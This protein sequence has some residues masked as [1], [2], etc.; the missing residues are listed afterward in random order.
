[1]NRHM[2][3]VLS[4]LAVAAAIAALTASLQA[5]ELTAAIRGRAISVDRQP[6]AEVEVTAQ[7]ASLPATARTRTGRDGAYLLRGL[8]PGDYVITFRAAGYV[9]L[10]RTTRLSALETAAMD[11]ELVAAPQESYDPIVAVSEGRHMFIRWPLGATTFRTADVY[12]LPL[13]GTPGSLLAIMPGSQLLSAPSLT[14]WNGVPVRGSALALTPAY[15]LN[16]EALADMTLARGGQPVD[17]EA[18]TTLAVAARRGSDRLAGALLA[19]GG[20]AGLAGDALW[21]TG[22][23]RAGD[24]T[25]AA[26][27]GGA[28]LPRHVWF[29]AQGETFGEEFRQPVVF[30]EPSRTRI[31][32]TSASGSLTF[33]WANRQRVELDA[34]LSRHDGEARV[35]ESWR[36]ASRAGAFSSDDEHRLLSAAFLTQLGRGPA[37]ELRATEE[38]SASAVVGATP[39]GFSIASP[40]NETRLDGGFGC[41]GCGSAIRTIRSTRAVARQ[42]LSAGGGSHELTFGAEQVEDR[43]ASSPE[44]G[45]RFE[46]LASRFVDSAG[47]LF[48]MLVPNGSAALIWYPAGTSEGTTRTSSA[49]LADSWRAGAGLTL[50]VGVRWDR[51][52]IR[53]GSTGRLLLET[54][55][56]SPRVAL[57]WQPALARG[58]RVSLGYGRYASSS[59]PLAAT[60]F[61][62]GA[63]RVYTYTGPAINT[64]TA[65]LLSNDQVI[66][67][68]QAWAGALAT[69]VPS[70]V[71]G[72]GVI[73]EST[74][75][76]SAI[77]EWSGGISKQFRMLE[78]RA[79]VLHR[80]NEGRLIPGAV[81]GVTIPDSLTG[82]AIDAR[83]IALDTRRAQRS[84]DIVLQ[85]HYRLGLQ[86]VTGASYTH[87][88]PAG[89]HVSPVHQWQAQGL[90]YPE[91]FTNTDGI[92]VA[93]RHRTTA[94]MVVQMLTDPS[95]GML[96]VGALF[97]VESSPRFGTVGWIDVTPYTTNPGYAQPPAAV[98]Y[99]FAPAG[100]SD[101]GG[102]W[103]LDFALRYTKPFGLKNRA[104]WFVRLDVLNIADQKYRLDRLRPALAVTALQDPV[105]FA[106]FD[107]AT[108]TPARGVHWE[109]DPWSGT[110]ARTMPRAIRWIGGFR[111]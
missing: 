77:R 28:L 91:Y 87:H 49:F 3:T 48:P 42:F 72:S 19:T 110:G 16:R 73:E 47:A 27:F 51:V 86:A 36:L 18:P 22:E 24:G 59:A 35:P 11:A 71:L 4:G 44:P 41:T 30:G 6:V 70:A 9:L 43:V 102:L 31:D 64:G 32:G 74:G 85:G 75:D 92:G 82:I 13:A 57:S 21:Q 39:G 63:A 107:P 15:T 83:E 76:T 62:T 17:V 109:V 96:S 81:P 80:R 8:P 45:G 7:S 55:G 14:I 98:P 29:F 79:D 37:L 84:T 50:D 54:D 56:L 52:R 111:F 95:T 106:P 38:R 88:R 65:P 69:R 46:I 61:G 67:A 33:A 100:D 90:G 93:A 12:E 2:S 5:Q 25:V 40:W 108:T 10:K 101:G 68:V 23:R 60:L 104:Q 20:T 103:R 89:E 1:M 26:S 94:W 53:E 78:L 97:R 99:L 105:R 34:V 66:A 58:L